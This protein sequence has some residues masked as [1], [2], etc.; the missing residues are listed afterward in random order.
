[1]RGLL[2]WFGWGVLAMSAGIGIAIVFWFL[3]NG[4]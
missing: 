2:T 3:N 4:V 1:M